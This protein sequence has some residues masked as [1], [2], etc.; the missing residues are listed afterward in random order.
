MVYMARI[1]RRQTVRASNIRKSAHAYY[2][3][4]DT[5]QER[6]G[7]SVGEGL[8]PCDTACASQGS[9]SILK[10]NCDTIGAD[11]TF[12][13]PF[14]TAGACFSFGDGGCA[15]E[16]IPDTVTNSTPTMQYDLS[17]SGLYVNQYKHTAGMGGGRVQGTDF[18]GST[19]FK[20]QYQSEKELN[21]QGGLQDGAEQL[22]VWYDDRVNEDDDDTR[23]T[24]VGEYGSRS[25]KFENPS[26][27]ASASCMVAGPDVG[28]TKQYVANLLDKGQEISA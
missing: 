17:A 28:H 26:N 19:F 13:V 4:A 21:A 10:K 25:L 9:A 11:G 6:T 5:T 23:P 20:L 22:N 2:T 24:L 14:G 8:N 1:V 12:H 7:G 3:F 18:A 27:E 15:M 16:A